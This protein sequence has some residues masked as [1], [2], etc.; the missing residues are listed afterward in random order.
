[1][2]CNFILAKNKNNLKLHHLCKLIQYFC[3]SFVKMM[4]AG[5]QVYHK[6]ITHFTHAHVLVYMFIIT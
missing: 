3:L 5:N 2:N 4:V 1:M 6:P